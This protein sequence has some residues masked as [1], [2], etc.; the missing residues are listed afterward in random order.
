MTSAITATSSIG[1]SASGG[2]QIAALQKQLL[3]LQKQLTEVSKSG[4]GETTATQV[5]LIAGQI[6]MVP[7][8]VKEV[9]A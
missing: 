7:V 3:S 8:D 4:V 5:E 1:A 6:A 9:V 2:S